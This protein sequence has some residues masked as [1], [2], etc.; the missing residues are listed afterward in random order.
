MRRPTDSTAKSATIFYN[1]LVPYEYRNT[2]IKSDVSFGRGH[3]T[4]V[5]NKLHHTK[6]DIT[7]CPSLCYRKFYVILTRLR[8]GYS[9]STHGHLLTRQ[10][11][12]VCT[13]CDFDITIFHN[14][15]ECVCFEHNRFKH[16]KSHFITLTDFLGDRPHH[17]YF[18]F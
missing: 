14:L 5:E 4:C 12:P 18:P 9:R 1:Y 2:W 6:P 15:V 13:V 3:W 16:F 17:N 10:S 11:N 7:H 8:I